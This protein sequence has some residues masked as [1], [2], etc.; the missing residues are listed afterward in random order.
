MSS[1]L[2]ERVQ[3]MLDFKGFFNLSFRPWTRLSYIKE[4]SILDDNA[5][6]L[7]L[8]SRKEGVDSRKRIIKL[9]LETVGK[10]IC[11]MIS[12]NMS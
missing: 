8:A 3:A 5:G 1:V 11:I 6:R 9:D 4:T 2:W 12:Q 10:F 7:W